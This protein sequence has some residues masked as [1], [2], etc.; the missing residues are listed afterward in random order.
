MNL[1]EKLEEIEVIAIV[2][3][4]GGVGKSN[5]SWHS[6]PSV[7]ATNNMSFQVFEIDDN[8][9]SFN[10][11]LS[12]IV[13]SENCKTVKTDDIDIASDI[14]F[15]TLAS[16]DKIVV[17]GGGGNDTRK[18]INLIKSVGDDVKK[19]WLVPF[20][21]NEDDFKL[22]LE[23]AELINSKE[24]TYF[25]LNAHSEKKL[26]EFAWFYEMKIKNY[27]EIPFSSLFTYAQKNQ[28]TIFDLSQISQNMNKAAAKKIFA[29]KFTKNGEL[30][31]DAF[32]KAFN[33]FLKS[34]KASEIVNQ[35]NKSFESTLGAASK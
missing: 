34:E 25:I 29:E 3:L 19:I 27:I 30:N 16:G 22:A 32:K 1:K 7:L 28:Q 11:K 9:Q 12:D 14:A 17:D 2:G 24:N 26:I 4:K 31:K 35:I 5:T 10:F 13:T 8:N 33:D 6:V 23:T 21:R 18:A 15:E 20:D